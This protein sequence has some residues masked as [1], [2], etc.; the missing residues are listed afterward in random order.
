MMMRG[1]CAYVSIGE[2]FRVSII[3]D[4]FEILRGEGDGSALF[5]TTQD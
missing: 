5:V 3:I 1:E 4:G 2:V